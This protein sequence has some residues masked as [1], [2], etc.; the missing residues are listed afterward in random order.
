MTKTE[1]YEV[2]GVPIELR[3]LRGKT[4]KKC[5]YIDVIMTTVLMKIV[6]IYTLAIM[7]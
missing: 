3:G 6:C 4:G 5:G 2:E 7:N 1:A